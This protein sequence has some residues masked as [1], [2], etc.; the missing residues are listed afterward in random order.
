MSV[1]SE[2][3]IQLEA[4]LMLGHRSLENSISTRNIFL[5]GECTHLLK[6]LHNT[7]DIPSL[8]KKKMYCL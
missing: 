2:D 5:E 3:G 7:N 8:E 1:G 6:G 4:W